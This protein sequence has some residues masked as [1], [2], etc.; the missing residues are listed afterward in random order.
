[1]ARAA[2]VGG[3]RW[4]SYPAETRPYG[5]SSVEKEEKTAR[6]K[7][8]DRLGHQPKHGGKKTGVLGLG[9][10]LNQHERRKKQNKKTKQT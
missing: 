4:V 5:G 10:I 8:E 3:S 7:T 6:R 2:V 9:F 1:V